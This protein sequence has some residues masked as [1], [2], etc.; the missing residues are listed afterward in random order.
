MSEIEMR[1]EH[2]QRLSAELADLLG[3]PHPGLATWLLAVPKVV[4]QMQAVLDGKV[5]R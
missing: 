5:T 1:V 2:L 4:R 3:D